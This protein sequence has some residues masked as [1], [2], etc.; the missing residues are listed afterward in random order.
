MEFSIVLINYNSGQ[1]LKNCLDSIFQNNSVDYTNITVYDNASSDDSISYA[2]TFY[3]DVLYIENATNIGFARAINRVIRATRGEYILLLNPDVILLPKAI[4]EM[5]QF[6]KKKPHCGVV[7]GEIVSPLGY[8]QPTCRRFPNYMNI[9]FGRRSLARRL[10]PNNPFSHRYLYLDLDCT[11]PQK[12][13]FVEG[14]VMMIR[15]K[16]LEDVGFFDEGFF[17]YLEDADI[18]Y[19]MNSHGWETWWLPRAYAIHFRGE[20]IRRDNI[21]PT[22]HHSKGF[23]RFF[24][25]HYH[26]F[27]PMRLLLQIFLALRL[28]YVISTESLKGVL[29]DAPLL[30]YN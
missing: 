21:H 26:P 27:F 17:L 3:P 5:L 30:S 16:A 8:Y 29:F 28:A 7:G 14:S 13:D 1:H 12:V 6:M 20:T 2:R 22:M 23:Y 25:K 19:R 9:L 11:V 18:C 24:M 15:R 4:D 10:F